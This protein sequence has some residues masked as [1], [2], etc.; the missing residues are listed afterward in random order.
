LIPYSRQTISIRD[1]LHVAWQ[2]KFR[3]LTQGSQIDKFEKSIADYV[4]AKFAVAVSSGTAGL[5]LAHLALGQPL[6]SKVITSP[7]SFVASANSILY[8]GQEPVFVDIDPDT[9]NLSVEKLAEVIDKHLIKTVVPVHYG[10]YPC[11]MEKIY[12]LCKRKSIKIVEDA[13][14]A[15]GGQYVS[16]EKIG[17]CKYSDLTVFSFH[18]VKSI[19]TGEGGVVTTNDENL[20]STLV[21]LR[22]HGITRNEKLLQNPILGN[23]DSR[24]NIWYYEMKSLGFHYRLTEM[25]AILGLSQMKRIDKF[26]KKRRKVSFR[27]DKLLSKVSNLDLLKTK[28][29][30]LSAF[31]LYSIKIKFD[32]LT[33]SKN[34]LMLKLRDSGIVTQVHYIPIPLHPYYQELGYKIDEIPNALEFYFRVLS[35]PIYPKLSSIKQK[36]VAKKL[37]KIVE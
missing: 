16:G 28:G 29:N 20:Y 8:A 34:D 11:D 14:H 3:S 5:H 33:I 26:I 4:G 19:T 17:S 13:A 10:G 18:P 12:S 32:N 37:V 35:I 6:G 23:T 36:K 31:H 30:P 1:A 15:L 9:G 25:Q 24:K 2:V 27:Y 7:I 21:N 22:S